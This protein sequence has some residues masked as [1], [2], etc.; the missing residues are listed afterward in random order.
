ME[1]IQDD[2]IALPVSAGRLGLTLQFSETSAIIAAINPAC[3]F[4][5]QINVGDSLESIDGVKVTKKEDLEVG[6]DKEVRMFSFVK[7]KPEQ[8]VEL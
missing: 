7:R 1:P 5:D 4:K 3:T 2:K 8:M 6:K